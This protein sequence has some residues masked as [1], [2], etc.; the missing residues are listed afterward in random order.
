MWFEI[1]GKKIEFGSKNMRLDCQY[2]KTEKTNFSS[3]NRLCFPFEIFHYP[4][5]NNDIYICVQIVIFNNKIL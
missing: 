5:D 3:N 4:A 2:I 1:E